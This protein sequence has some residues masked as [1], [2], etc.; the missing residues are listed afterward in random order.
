MTELTIV[1]YGTQLLWLRSQPCPQIL[2]QDGNDIRYL[3]Q[4]YQTNDQCWHTDLLARQW[5]KT[6][7]L[8][9]CLCWAC[10]QKTWIIL[11]QE[12]FT[13]SIF[14]E[15]RY[16][17]KQLFCL[18][19]ICFLIGRNPECYIGSLLH[20]LSSDSTQKN[21]AFY[22]Y[23]NDSMDIKGFILLCFLLHYL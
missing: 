18:Q 6:V 3:Q 5:Y 23:L 8:H 20:S 15:R 17:Q 9:D 4:I 7:T 19:S 11:Q 12:C 13:P 2:D 21:E 22:I 10:L 16:I 1:A 14:W